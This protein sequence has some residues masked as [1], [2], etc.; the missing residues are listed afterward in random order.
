LVRD[1]KRKISDWQIFKHVRSLIEDGNKLTKETLSL[2]KLHRFT[3]K[4]VIKY[5]S[6][7]ALLAGI[8]TALGYNTKKGHTNPRRIVKNGAGLKINI[9]FLVP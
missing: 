6:L 3:L 4:S 5:V 8:I 7:N 9:K 1:F 2:D